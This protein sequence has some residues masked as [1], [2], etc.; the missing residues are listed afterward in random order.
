MQVYYDYL[1]YI[2]VLRGVQYIIVKVTRR[3]G[4]LQCVRAHA[5]VTLKNGLSMRFARFTRFTRV[6]LFFLYI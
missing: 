3:R 4:T 2:I 5:S 1:K 6:F